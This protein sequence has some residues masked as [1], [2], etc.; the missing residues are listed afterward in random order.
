MLSTIMTDIRHHIMIEL[1]HPV[2][3]IRSGFLLIVRGSIGAFMEQSEQSKHG[4][5]I[6]GIGLGIR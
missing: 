5:D 1:C 2:P 6:T 3:Y 4:R